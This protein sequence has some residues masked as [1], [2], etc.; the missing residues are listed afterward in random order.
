MPIIE[1]LRAYF[2]QIFGYAN[3]VVTPCS[4]LWYKVTLAFKSTVSLEYITK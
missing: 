2:I 3:N 1:F 4:P